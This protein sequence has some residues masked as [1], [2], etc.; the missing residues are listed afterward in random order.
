MQATTKTKILVLLITF[1][2]FA[3]FLITDNAANHIAHAYSSGPPAGFTHA[4]GEFDCAE[5]HLPQP[6]AGTGQ[7]SIGAPQSYVPGQTYQITVT[8]TNTDPSRLRWGFQ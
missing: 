6:D 1:G 4:P 3:L 5:C 8:H 2:G 7:I